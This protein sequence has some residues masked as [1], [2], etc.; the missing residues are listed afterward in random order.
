MYQMNEV[1]ALLFS[2]IGLVI[3]LIFLKKGYI[4]RIPFLLAAYGCIVAS[5]TF[6]VIEGFLLYDIFNMCEHLSDLA[7]GIFMVAA[8]VHYKKRDTQ[9]NR[10]PPS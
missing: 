1:M 7:S 5:N 9:W 4:Q 10:Q 8:I 3:I 2:I 6:T